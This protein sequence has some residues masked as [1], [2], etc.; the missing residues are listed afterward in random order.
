MT[1]C[2]SQLNKYWLTSGSR[3]RN[4]S[5]LIAGDWNLDAGKAKR[6]A[7]RKAGFRDAVGLPHPAR[8]LRAVV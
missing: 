4:Q 5:T 2:V 7:L 8:G 1:P 3:N 6:S